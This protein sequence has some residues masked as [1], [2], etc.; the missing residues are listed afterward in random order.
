MLHI[1]TNPQCENMKMWYLNL[2]QT[3]CHHYITFMAALPLDCPPDIIKNECSALIYTHNKHCN[4]KSIHI[5][6]IH[7]KFKGITVNVTVSLLCDW[8]C[9]GMRIEVDRKKGEKWLFGQNYS[10]N[11]SILLLANRHTWYCSYI[12]QHINTCSIEIKTNVIFKGSYLWTN[13]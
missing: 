1:H 5:V 2:T 9:E 6:R 7:T 11:N 13:T 3:D 4:S 10:E 8:M 12:T